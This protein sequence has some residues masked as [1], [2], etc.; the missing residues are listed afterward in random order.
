MKLRIAFQA[1]RT[2]TI[3]SAIFQLGHSTA[4]AEP[5]VVPT[6]SRMA[7]RGNVP[8]AIQQ[9]ADHLQTHPDDRDAREL[10]SQLYGLQFN[11]S[12]TVKDLSFLI[13]HS[14]KQAAPDD[15]RRSATLARW[16]DARGA[17]YFKNGDI[18]A[19]IN[20]FDE[21][22][23]QQPQRERSHWRRGISCY[24]AG[25]YARGAKQ[26]ELYQAYDAADV[27][28]VVW[29][30]LCQVQAGDRTPDALKQARRD[31]LPLGAP[32]RR[33]PM[34]EIDALFR[35]NGSSDA[36]FAAAKADATAAQ[37]H[38]RM[39]YAHLY[40]GLF[41]EVSNQ[42]EQAREHLEAADKLKIGHYMWDVAHVHA[43]R[44]QSDDSQK[45]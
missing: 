44:L 15:S 30:F 23:R 8:A 12:A 9:L 10:R 1:I 28:N 13:D 32:D 19:S 3:A 18:A 29:R 39:F 16:L 25:R 14:T 6:A 22:I 36:V 42:P 21:A 33:V 45:K 26:F 24:Y 20:D 17:A 35:G 43:Q 40:V 41:C 5:Q 31:M 7:Q 11:H 34:T 37:K 4:K 38:S 2:F 27:E